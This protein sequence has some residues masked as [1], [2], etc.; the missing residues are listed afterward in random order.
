MRVPDKY[1]IPNIPDFTN[2][3]AGSH[4]FTTLDLVKGYYIV[5]MFP[6][7]IPKTAVIKP[8]GLFEFVQM[9]FGLRNA[10]STFQ[11]LMDHVLAGLPFIFVYLDDVLVASSDHASHRKHLHEVL[12]H[13]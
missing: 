9:P 8:F 4:V 10:G 7:N 6:D 13:L 12:H 1:P 3:V 5:E 2:N 11:C